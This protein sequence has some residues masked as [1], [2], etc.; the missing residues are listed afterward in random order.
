MYKK[1]QKKEKI[2]SEIGIS[3][4][5]QASAYFS[6]NAWLS[7]L[8][9]ILFVKISLQIRFCP[10]STLPPLRLFSNKLRY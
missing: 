10:D 2:W 7:H 8:I 5:N 6:D 9:I 1:E 4:V 3:F